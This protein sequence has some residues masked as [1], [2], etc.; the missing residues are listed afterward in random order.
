MPHD[1]CRMIDKVPHDRCRALGTGRWGRPDGIAFEAWS[2]SGT[3]LRVTSVYV[4]G[5]TRG[6][7]CGAVIPIHE[8]VSSRYRG[9]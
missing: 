7:R 5:H 2:V 4:F 6:W 1:R 3:Y 9:S 8:L